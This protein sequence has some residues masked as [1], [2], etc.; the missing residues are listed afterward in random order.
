MFAKLQ[1]KLS[2]K[3]LRNE[4]LF[5]MCSEVLDRAADLEALVRNSTYP[6]WS[7]GRDDKSEVKLSKQDRFLRD[8]TKL[9][10]LRKELLL[11]ELRL[12]ASLCRLTAILGTEK[13][14][15][16]CLSG[17]FVRSLDKEFTNHDDAWNPDSSEATRAFS[18]SYLS[19]DGLFPFGNLFDEEA[20]ERLFGKMRGE[21]EV[22]LGGLFP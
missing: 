14:A 1:K 17:H 2:Y 10:N 16:S 18:G 12:D 21:I 9:R 5:Q 6:L 4:F 13:P 11:L 15:L 19:K 7:E 22:I 3:S 8:W 20:T